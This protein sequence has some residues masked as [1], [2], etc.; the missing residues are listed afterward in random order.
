M[1]HDGKV[2]SLEE[3]LEP[4][5]VIIEFPYG[6]IEQIRHDVSIIIE[7]ATAKGTEH[8]I[9]VTEVCSNLEHTGDNCNGRCLLLINR[10]VSLIHDAQRV[11]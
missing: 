4:Q 6:S 8:E 1:I 11:V 7:C 10:I 2:Y 5:A 3:I 9:F